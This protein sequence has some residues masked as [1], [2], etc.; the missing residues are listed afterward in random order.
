MKILTSIT[1]CQEGPVR[2]FVL[3][4]K[5]SVSPDAEVI[6]E[7]EKIFFTTDN[8]RNEL[9]EFYFNYFLFAIPIP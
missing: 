2:Y 4:W 8:E 7:E 5:H 1:E 3:Q 6:F 9:G